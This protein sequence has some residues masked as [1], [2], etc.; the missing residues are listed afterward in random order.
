MITKALFTAKLSSCALSGPMQGPPV[1]DLP[2]RHLENFPQAF[3]HVADQY[4]I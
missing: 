4:R 1:Q 2:K 3:T